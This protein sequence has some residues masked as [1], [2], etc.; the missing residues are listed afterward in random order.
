MHFPFIVLGNKVDLDNRIV[1]KR[2]VKEWC[3][4]NNNIPYFETS[5]KDGTNLD[6]AFKTLTMMA[7]EVEEDV[8]T[9][10]FYF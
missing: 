1:S 3:E 6:L 2:E 5:A 9:Q 10:I 8:G 4:R 7:V